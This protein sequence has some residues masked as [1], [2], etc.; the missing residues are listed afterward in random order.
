MASVT[1]VKKESSGPVFEPN[2]R[3]DY[4]E[5][6]GDRKWRDWRLRRRRPDLRQRFAPTFP[7]INSAIEQNAQA[8][9]EEENQEEAPFRSK[10]FEHRSL[11]DLKEKD[12]NG[13]EYQVDQLQF[14][15]LDFTHSKVGTIWASTR[16]RK[17]AAQDELDALPTFFFEEI[18]TSLFARVWE[19]AAEAVGQQVRDEKTQQFRDDE[20]P[21]ALINNRVP[22]RNWTHDFLRHLPEDFVRIASVTARADP[23]FKSESD[24]SGYEYMFIDRESRINLCTSVIAKLL[25]E[26]CLDSLLFGAR[27]VEREALRKIDESQEGVP[28]GSYLPARF[29]R[30]RP[31]SRVAN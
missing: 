9:I 8:Q 30:F 13:Q 2:V 18:S 23:N 16:P 3:P 26:Q 31:E 4:I 28:N 12:L 7:A 19:F 11:E 5:I 1:F 14:R 10:T 22:G 17:Q 25:Q 21:E 24:P 29:C 20:T 27:K 6:G 15:P